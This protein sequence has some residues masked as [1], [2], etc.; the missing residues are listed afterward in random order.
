MSDLLQFQAHNWHLVMQE[1]NWKRRNPFRKRWKCWG[2]NII[3]EN[4]LQIQGK[5]E[6]ARRNF[7]GLYSPSIFQ[8]LFFLLKN[9]LPQ[10]QRKQ[11]CTAV[12]YIQ[13][14][15]LI[16][17]YMVLKIIMEFVLLVLWPLSPMFMISGLMCWAE[18]WWMILSQKDVWENSYLP[19]FQH[20][21]QPNSHSPNYDKFH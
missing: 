8:A 19:T 6:I 15:R 13:I 4:C 7:E 2:E 5:Y 14:N 18:N 3:F 11:I 16:V 1:K 10:L 21:E 12:R 9:C 20:Q 17:Q